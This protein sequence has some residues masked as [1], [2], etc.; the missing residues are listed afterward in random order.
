MFCISVKNQIKKVFLWI[1]LSCT[2]APQYLKSHKFNEIL[3]FNLLVSFNAVFAANFEILQTRTF[4]ELVTLVR[5]FPVGMIEQLTVAILLLKDLT[6][7][8]FCASVKF[9]IK[10]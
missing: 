10:L 7:E 8:L 2:I 1:L 3:K 4:F 9:G 6:Y 5:C